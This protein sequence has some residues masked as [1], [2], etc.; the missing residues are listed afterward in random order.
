V[1]VSTARAGS[2]SIAAARP[3]A[4]NRLRVFSMGR[5]RG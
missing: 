5:L 2:A 1:M 4:I 3:A